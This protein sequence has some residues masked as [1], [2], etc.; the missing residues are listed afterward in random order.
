MAYEWPKEPKVIGT[1]VPRVDGPA[2]ASGFAKYTYDVNR[3]GML[4]AVFL[5]SP[6][7]HATV[8]AIDTAQATQMPGVAG[9]HIVANPGAELVYAGQPVLALAAQTEAQAYDALRAVKVKYKVLPHSVK[10]MLSKQ[11]GSPKVSLKDDNVLSGRAQTTGNFEAAF[12]QAA[13]KVEGRYGMPAISHSCLET[14]GSVAEWEGDRLTVWCSTQNTQGVAGELGKAFGIPVT[15][16]SVITHVMGGGFGCKFNAGTE[17]LAAAHLAKATGK[18]VKLMIDRKEEHSAGIRPPIW[19]TVKA[20]ADKTGKL[21]AFHSRSESSRGIGGGNNPPLPYVYENVPNSDTAGD[22]YRINQH[23]ARAYRAPN[24]PQTCFIM[25]Q[26]VDDLAAKLGMDPLQ[27]RL[28]NLPEG[29]IGEI[30]RK[31]IEIGAQLFGWKKKWHPPGK[32]AAGPIKRGVGMGCHK[33]GG[34]GVVNEQMLVEINSDG[35]VLVQS[36]TQDLGTG[37]R[38]V[39][40]IV[41]AEV[42]GLKPEQISAD[43]GESQWAKSHGSGGSTTC[44]STAPV[45][46]VAAIDARTKL[47]ERLAPAFEAK[48]EDLVAVDGM[49]MVKG[50]ARSMTWKDA[51]RKLGL[52]KV[53]VVGEFT[54][55]RMDELSS[56][57]VGG[58]QFAEVEVDEETGQVRCVEVVAVQ[59]CGLIINKQGCESQVAGGVV[60]AVN[61]ALYEERVMDQ[62]SGRL[63][64]ADME[65]YKLGSISDMP[66]IKVHMFEDPISQSRGVIG[67]GE[68]P[69]ISG[70]GAIANAVHNALG[71]RCPFA[72]L[73]PRNVLAAISQAKKGGAA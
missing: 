72:P 6:H 42:L 4:H 61:A 30:Y 25:E 35:S 33:W 19:A 7:A 34:R 8:E 52:E 40:A 58:C 22:T 51:C 29:L 1:R 36:S 13:A 16:V 31:E 28:V 55:E 50:G 56:V 18:P 39:L 48:P 3:P 62:A 44:P 20:G 43:I 27:M 21:I 71:I 10:E 24:H 17:G 57:N 66:R 65:F 23:E 37:N 41:A 59:D 60:M 53:S 2:K 5:P 12:A 67:I 47:F 68:P 64:N 69:T 11:G 38:T 46:L 26:V 9:I 14:H 49:V 73:T 70:A 63:L 32:G 54:K 45:T 15:N